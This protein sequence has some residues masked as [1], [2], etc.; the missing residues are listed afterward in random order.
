[1]SIPKDKAGD[2]KWESNSGA[3]ERQGRKIA[4]PHKRWCILWVASGP[5]PFATK[6]FGL[7]VA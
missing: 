6:M 7:L 4:S 5:T 3:V 1:M 2:H